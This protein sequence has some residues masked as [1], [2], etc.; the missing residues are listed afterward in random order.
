MIVGRSFFQKRLVNSCTYL[1]NGTNVQTAV[2]ALVESVRIGH[3][4]CA[5]MEIYIST[6]KR[7][8]FAVTKYAGIIGNKF[9]QNFNVIFD[10]KR[11]RLNLE[12]Y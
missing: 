3:F 9:F 6:S 5:N 11:K 4:E 12:K 7:G 1:R 10:Y 8:L 2:A